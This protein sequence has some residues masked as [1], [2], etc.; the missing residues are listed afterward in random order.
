M[1]NQSPF[2]G[3][4]AE[5][6]EVKTEQKHT[7]VILGRIEARLFGDGSEDNPGLIADVDRLKRS[8]RAKMWVLCAAVTAVIGFVADKVSGFFK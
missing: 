7:N 2:E 6:A 4:R 3:M 8:E 5:L 1:P